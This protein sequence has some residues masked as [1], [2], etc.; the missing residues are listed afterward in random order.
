LATIDDLR[1]VAKNPDPDLIIAIANLLDRKY[2]AIFDCF[3]RTFKLDD[4]AEERT[5]E[6]VNK[7]FRDLQR[8]KK[9]LKELWTVGQFIPEPL[10]QQI[11]E[12]LNDA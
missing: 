11:E 2:E 10:A 6:A 7:T 5:E 1:L 3:C 4:Y 8:T 9:V 12:I